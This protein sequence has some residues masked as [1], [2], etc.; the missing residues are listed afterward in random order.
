MNLY[1]DRISKKQK[2]YEA[3][4]IY[5]NRAFGIGLTSSTVYLYETKRTEN[6]SSDRW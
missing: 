1:K 3:N 4:N 6:G 5:I 2:E